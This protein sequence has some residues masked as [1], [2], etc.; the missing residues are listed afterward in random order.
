MYTTTTEHIMRLITWNT[1]K[2]TA[3]AYQFIVKEVI[4]TEDRQLDGEYTITNVL[5]TGTCK[6]R[7]QAKISGVRWAKR[8]RANN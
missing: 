5:K 6:T 1:K 8:F 3:K 2:K 7:A 4:A